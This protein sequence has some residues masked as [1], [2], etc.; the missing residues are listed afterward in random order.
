VSLAALTVSTSV[1][2]AHRHLVAAVGEL[3]DVC[4]DTGPSVVDIGE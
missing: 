4:F 2:G 3:A 1:G